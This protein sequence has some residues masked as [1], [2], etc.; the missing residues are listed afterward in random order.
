MLVLVVAR[1]R[2]VVE[3]V[4][5]AAVNDESPNTSE[6][7][8]IVLCNMAFLPSGRTN[9]GSLRFKDPV[10]PLNV[11]QCIHRVEPGHATVQAF[12]RTFL[13]ENIEHFKHRRPDSLSG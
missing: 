11:A 4:F 8:S 10:S 3:L 5:C 1:G 7:I 12:N 13:S 6:I 9:S 2:V